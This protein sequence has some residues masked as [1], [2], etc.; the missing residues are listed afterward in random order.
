MAEDWYSRAFGE[1]YPEL[2]AH[3]NQEEAES[4][5]DLVAE[6]T[7]LD[8]RRVVDVACGGGR[9]L[10]ALR[11]RGARAAGVDL[12]R[13]LLARAGESGPVVRGD[14]RHLP[15]RSGSIGG[16]INMFT[17]FGYFK[18]REENES[19]LHE[20]ARILEPGGWF[21]LDYLN[22]DAV[23]AGLVPE[24]ERNVGGK[25]VRET[26]RFDPGSRYLVK[27]VEILGGD[28]EPEG[29]WSE[30]LLLYSGAEIEEALFGAGLEPAR[31]FGGYDGAP[32]SDGS[33]RLI[34]FS[35]RKP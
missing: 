35:V 26:R 17:S 4:G 34:I 27:E 10:R 1:K 30:R 29:R 20:V 33:D 32:P 8:G 15:F 6:C 7:D 16:A 31:R 13:A 28:G 11:K 19:V 9:H 18:T 14:M 12:S 22:R 2:Y 25:R 24:G 21:F 3:R 5:I 23:L